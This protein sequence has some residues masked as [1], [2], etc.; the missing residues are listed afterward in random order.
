MSAGRKVA[1]SLDLEDAIGVGHSLL[2]LVRTAM[3]P[4]ETKDIYRRVAR[5]LIDASRQGMQ[6]A[7]ADA[8]EVVNADPDLDAAGVLQ[9][10][11]NS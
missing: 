4:D 3:I 9:P 1:V 7:C 6:P 2:V 8:S 5:Q 10:P 11:V